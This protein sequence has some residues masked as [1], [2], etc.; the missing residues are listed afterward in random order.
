[1]T[2]HRHTA[3]TITDDALDELYE[4]ASEGWR[5]G[6]RWKRRALEAEASAEG[7][8]SV[9]PQTLTAIASHLDARA[10]AILR[11]GSEAYAEWQ[12]AIA[13]LRRTAAGARQ[14][15]EETSAS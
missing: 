7:L 9:R 14:D 11:P 1:M 5:R 13:W 2:K 8:A 10:V 12:T 3:S 15:P 6:D 4:N